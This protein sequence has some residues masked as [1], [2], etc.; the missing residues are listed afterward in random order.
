METSLDVGSN[1]TIST[2]IN[3]MNWDSIDLTTKI[4][5]LER[6][7]GNCTEG[8]FETQDSHI[9]RAL[10]TGSENAYTHEDLRFDMKNG[11]W[12]F[13]RYTW[14]TAIKNQKNNDVISQIKN[15]FK[16]K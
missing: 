15:R 6:L 5:Y 2:K 4:K 10:I 14:E 16:Y 8:T 9:V 3:L 11:H 7:M 1:P 13:L 12:K